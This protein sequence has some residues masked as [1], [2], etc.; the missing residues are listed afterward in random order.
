MIFGLALNSSAAAQIA[1][2]SRG[3]RAPPISEQMP[4]LS[5]C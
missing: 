2:A 3:F 4:E 1:I 5:V